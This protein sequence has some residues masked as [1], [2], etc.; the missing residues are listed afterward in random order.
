LRAEIG[1]SQQSATVKVDEIVP[2]ADARSRTVL[3]KAR[4][5]DATKWIEGQYGRLFVPLSRESKL[6]VPVN[7]IQSI[8]QLDFVEVVSKTGGIERRFVKLATTSPENEIEILSGL[9]AGERVMLATS[10]GS[11]SVLRSDERN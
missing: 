6:F 5:P 1:S 8:G 3:V 4:L 7:A 9:E 10:T 11:S 2:Q